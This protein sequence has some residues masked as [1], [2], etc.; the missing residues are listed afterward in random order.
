SVKW[1]LDQMNDNG[2]WGKENGDINTTSLSLITLHE[3]IDSQ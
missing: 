2:S 3:Y 1:I